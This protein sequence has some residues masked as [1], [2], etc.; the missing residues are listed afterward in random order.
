MLQGTSVMDAI[1]ENEEA[2]KE[3]FEQLSTQ[4]WAGKFPAGTFTLQNYEW[5]VS[6]VSSRSV[7]AEKFPGSLIL[8][9]FVDT[10]FTSMPSTGNTQLFVYIYIYIYI[11]MTHTHTHTHTHPLSTLLAQQCPPQA[12]LSGGQ[13]SIL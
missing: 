7:Y 1:E 6:I 13:H 10:A 2:F 5:A 4:G 9:P 11:Y 12:T 3:E 8:A